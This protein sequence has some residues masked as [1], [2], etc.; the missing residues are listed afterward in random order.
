MLVGDVNIIKEKEEVM[1]LEQATILNEETMMEEVIVLEDT[2]IFKE[3]T[4]VED[5]KIHLNTT[6]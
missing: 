4:M 6:E 1:F 2:T 3:K 5:S